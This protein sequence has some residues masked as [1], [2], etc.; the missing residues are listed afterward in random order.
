MDTAGAL[1][2]YEA[3]SWAFFAVDIL[4]FYFFKPCDEQKSR[5]G[6]E[7]AL[8]QHTLGNPPLWL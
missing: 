6:Y 1:C 4:F 7:T 8:S 2:E 3:L 5:S